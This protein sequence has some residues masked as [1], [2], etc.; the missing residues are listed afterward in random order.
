[1][2]T[3]QNKR[4]LQYMKDNGSITTMQAFADLGITRLSARISDLKDEGNVIVSRMVSRKRKDGTTTRYS[5][6]S[7]GGDSDR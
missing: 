7:L 2:K 4:V 6:Y 1:M 3:T 5:V